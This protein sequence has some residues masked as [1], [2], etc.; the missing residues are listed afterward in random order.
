[1]VKCGFNVVKCGVEVV[2]CG[3]KV[4]KSGVEVAKTIA[5]KLPL[6]RLPRKKRGFDP[7]LEKRVRCHYYATGYTARDARTLHATHGH[8]GRERH[9][10][11]EHGKPR[12]GTARGARAWQITQGHGKLLMKP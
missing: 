6:K 2:K 5:E 3:F 9:T 4:A 12:T 7:W 10:A 8:G 11:Q 1:M